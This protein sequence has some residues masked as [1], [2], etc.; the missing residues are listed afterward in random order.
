MKVLVFGAAMAALAGFNQ[1]FELDI[2]P[3]EHGAVTNGCANTTPGEE[4]F[5]TSFE[6]FKCEAARIIPFD[7]VGCLMGAIH[8]KMRQEE[9]LLEEAVGDAESD[10]ADLNEHIDDVS[11]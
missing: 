8:V 5:A 2:A 6:L 11:G 4:Q 7:R 10:A 9:N 1:F 3:D